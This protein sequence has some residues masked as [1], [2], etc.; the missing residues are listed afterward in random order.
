MRGLKT[1]TPVLTEC[2]GQLAELG[3]VEIALQERHQT[4]DMRNAGIGVPVPVTQD[5]ARKIAR[6]NAVAPMTMCCA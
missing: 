1:G 3:D 4:G 6:A 5:R 2:R